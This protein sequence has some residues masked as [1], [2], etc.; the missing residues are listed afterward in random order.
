[1]R[2]WVLLHLRLGLMVQLGRMRVLG[3]LRGLWY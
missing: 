2:V 3:L 1:L